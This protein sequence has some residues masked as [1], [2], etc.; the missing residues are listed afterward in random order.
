LN[1][2]FNANTDRLPPYYHPGRAMRLGELAVFGQL[3]PDYAS[4]YKLRQPIYMAELDIEIMMEFDSRPL[5]SSVPKF[6]SIRRD[7]SLLLDNKI[8][9]ADV[10]KSVQDM[11]IPELSRIQPFDRM[12]SGPFAESKYALAISLTYQS[13]DRTLTDE[14]IE[15]FDKRILDSLKQRLG[16]QLRQ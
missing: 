4:E 1:A 16:A 2:S 12:D 6:P 8:R 13:M 14:E 10:E 9:Y 3:H 5:I 7:F 15:N 11:K